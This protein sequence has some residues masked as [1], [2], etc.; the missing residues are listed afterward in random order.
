MRHRVVG[1]A[2]RALAAMTVS[3]C[4]LALDWNSLSSEPSSSSGGGLGGGGLGGGGLAGA[5][6]AGD[7]G[8]AGAGPCVAGKG[9]AMVHIEVGNYCIDS[10]EVTNAHYQTFLDDGPDT[11]GQPAEC[12]FNEAGGS[13]LPS[14]WPMG[15]GSTTYPVAYVDWCDAAAFCAWAGKALCGAITGGSVPFEQRTDAAVSQWHRACTRNGTRPYPYGNEYQPVCNG[16]P[17]TG[18]TEADAVAS[19]PECEGGYDG[20]FDMVGN[21]LE[22]EDSCQPEMDGELDLCSLRGD[23]YDENGLGSC[24]EALSIARATG[25]APYIGFRCCAPAR[26][27]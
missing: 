17:G 16:G 18:A 7:G 25:N 2:A 26:T 15:E 9:P 3:A 24:A 23:D 8:A 12:A 21:V 6:V 14:R 10:T 27:E 20:I 19:H 4:S 5:G 1:G 13:F 22:W 11:A